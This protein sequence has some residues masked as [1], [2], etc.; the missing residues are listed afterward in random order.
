[1]IT[2]IYQMAAVLIFSLALPNNAKADE[3][4]LHKY[5]EVEYLDYSDPGYMRLKLSSGEVVEAGFFYE[6]ISH[7]EISSWKNGE[8]L[9]V[10]FSPARGFGLL[11][12]TNKQHF[13]VLFDDLE[14][15]ITT[16]ERNCI[17]EIKAESTS[18]IL[19]CIKLSITYWDAEYQYLYK[20]LYERSSKDKKA[21][22]EE[23]SDRFSSLNESLLRTYEEHIFE[24]KGSIGRLHFAKASIE[25]A[26]FRVRIISTFYQ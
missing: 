14:Y 25:F 5:M 18:E 3:S 22:L 9:V 2:L 17:D 7:E 1:M 21:L 10:T 13:K 16:R 11:R 23:L 26:R 8:R 19:S 12:S 4:G 6:F 20:T 24:K 15:I